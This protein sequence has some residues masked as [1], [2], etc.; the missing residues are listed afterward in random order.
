MLNPEIRYSVNNSDTASLSV[1]KTK[2]TVSIAETQ[3]NTVSLT[4]AP[5]TMSLSY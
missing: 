3:G 4:Q 5:G 2:G 1:M